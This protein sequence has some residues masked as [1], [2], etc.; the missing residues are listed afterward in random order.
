MRIGS[1]LR[2]N[3]RK[4]RR[5]HTFMNVCKP[6]PDRRTYVARRTKSEAAAHARAAARRRGARV[7]RAGR[8]AHVARRSRR[9]RGRD[10]RR[11]LLAL[12]RQG[13]PASTR[14]A[15]AATLPMERCSQRAGERG[16]DDPLA[17][18]RTL[19]I[20]ALT[21][22][23]TD[24]RTQAVFDVDLPQ[25]ASSPTSSRRSP[26]RRDRERCDCLSH[27]E[28]IVARARR[29]GPAAADTDTRAR[30]AGAARLHAAASC[31]SGCS[32]PRAYDLARAAP[33]LIDIDARRARRAD[34]PR[35]AGERV[36]PTT[37]ARDASLADAS[38][39]TAP[40]APRH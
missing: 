40:R 38:S 14:C 23:A 12:P 39:G 33:A 8:H 18:L 25:D 5:L 27:V 37:R 2:R 11:R 9:R 6:R 20:D 17:A 34:P 10:A 3:L 31:T 22:L 16:A 29:R 1:L 15:S 35:R 21:R 26:T 32:I 19:A 28:R 7:P 4:Q 30:H 13:R 24:P 36:R